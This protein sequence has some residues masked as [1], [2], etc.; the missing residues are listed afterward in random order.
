MSFRIPPRHL[1]RDA[2]YGPASATPAQ[3]AHDPLPPTTCYDNIREAL[4]RPPE[5]EKKLNYLK[6]LNFIPDRLFK[7]PE[8]LQ[9]DLEDLQSCF[10]VFK[11][12]CET[13]PDCWPDYLAK[14]G[15]DIRRP[16]RKDHI[17]YTHGELCRL[18]IRVH[19]RKYGLEVG[20]VERYRDDRGLT[21]L[22]MAV[23]AGRPATCKQ[24][25]KQCHPNAAFDLQTMPERALRNREIGMG[26][27][28]YAGMT[29]LTFAVEIKAS[30]EIINCFK[31]HQLLSRPDDRGNT[32]LRAAILARSLNHVRHLCNA[33]PANA[34]A[35]IQDDDGY[36]PLAVA[37]RLGEAKIVEELLKRDKTLVDRDDKDHCAPVVLAR[38]WPNLP[39]KVREDIYFTLSDASSTDDLKLLL[40]IASEHI[41]NRNDYSLAEFLIDKEEPSLAN[42]VRV[43]DCTLVQ[44]HI[45]RGGVCGCGINAEELEEAIKVAQARHETE[46]LA[47]L[48]TLPPDGVP[49][50]TPVDPST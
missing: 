13:L 36:R 42:L 41:K 39:P 6:F 24:L 7:D 1:Q 11:A 2:P 15:H 29:A 37:V 16:V 21:P 14:A 40:R 10:T 28:R 18:A 47:L 27:G 45:D 8:N 25:L 43:G 49:S 4:G 35:K 48:K 38:E 33:D 32:P 34:A 50:K 44:L 9:V 5:L 12:I 30:K 19:A 46:I 3:P 17:A 31:D 23:A 20:E 26:H 22:G